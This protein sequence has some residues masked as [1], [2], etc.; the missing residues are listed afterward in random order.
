MPFQIWFYGYLAII[1]LAAVILTA[2]DK[3]A[4]RKKKRRVSEKALL[5][6]AVLGGSIAMFITMKCIRHKTKKRKFMIGIPLIIVA[7]TALIYFF[8]RFGL[9]FIEKGIFWL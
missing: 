3:S 7:Q 6:V 4:A 2:A 9:P 1:S 5:S 8:C